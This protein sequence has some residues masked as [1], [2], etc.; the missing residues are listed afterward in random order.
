MHAAPQHQRARL[1]GGSNRILKRAHAMAVQLVGTHRESIFALARQLYVRGS[2]TGAEVH[3]SFTRYAP[4][5]RATRGSMARLLIL[6]R[7][8]T[9]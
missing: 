8:A 6:Q 1:G 9:S 5:L 4:N 7:C 2:L 3:A